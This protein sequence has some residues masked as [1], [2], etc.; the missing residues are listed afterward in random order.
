MNADTLSGRAQTGTGEYPHPLVFQADSSLRHPQQEGPQPLL[1]LLLPRFAM[2]E[3]K[4]D[5]D[6]SKGAKEE[7]R[8][9]PERS[10]HP[11]LDKNGLPD[12]KTAIEQDA[13]GARIDQSQG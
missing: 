4:R 7:D 13:E 6:A 2:T 12:D 10:D 3:T 1:L 5:Q 8:P 9:G 11:G